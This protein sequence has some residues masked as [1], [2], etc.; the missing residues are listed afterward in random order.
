[1]ISFFLMAYANSR[2]SRKGAKVAKKN[3]NKKRRVLF[4]L[5]KKSSPCGSS[6]II[7][8]SGSIARALGVK[9]EKRVIEQKSASFIGMFDRVMHANHDAAL[10]EWAAA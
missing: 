4:H 9:T 10:C 6:S 2:I 1:M 8:P 5:E 7:R 3:R